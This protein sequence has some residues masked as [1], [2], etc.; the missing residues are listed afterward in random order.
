MVT[1][2]SNDDVEVVCIAA[3][4]STQNLQ[5]T[6]YSLSGC[7]HQLSYRRSVAHAMAK[8]TATTTYIQAFRKI[9]LTFYKLKEIK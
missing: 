6:R 8:A 7:L 4:L 9:S 5:R 3:E 2:L 1:K